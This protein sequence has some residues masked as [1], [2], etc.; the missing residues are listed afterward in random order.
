MAFND[1][2]QSEV[3]LRKTDPKTL[4]KPPPYGCIIIQVAHEMH[5]V[6]IS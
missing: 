3:R 6:T 4:I 2:A 1:K 5:D